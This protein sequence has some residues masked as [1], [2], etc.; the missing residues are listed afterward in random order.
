MQ[1]IV[2]SGVLRIVLGCVTFGVISLINEIMGIVLGVKVLT[3][4]DEEYE[5]QKATI[6]MGVPK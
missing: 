6:T 4:S 1:G 5:Q 3:M 2:K